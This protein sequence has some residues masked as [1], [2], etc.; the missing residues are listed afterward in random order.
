MNYTPVLQPFVAVLPSETLYGI[1]MKF[2]GFGIADMESTRVSDDI[3]MPNDISI[4]FR[5]LVIL[6]IKA[7][8]LLVSM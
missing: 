6:S 4:F 3:L 2:S 1:H 5:L 8:F 7:Q